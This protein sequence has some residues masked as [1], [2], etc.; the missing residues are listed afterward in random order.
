MAEMFVRAGF[1]QEEKLFVFR[2]AFF[3]PMRTDDTDKFS[4]YGVKFS[5]CQKEFRHCVKFG[6]NKEFVENKPLCDDIY[7]QYI[8]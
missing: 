2:R 5:L 8:W 1:H 3:S 7:C 6:L 4:P